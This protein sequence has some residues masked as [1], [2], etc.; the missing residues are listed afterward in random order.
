MYLLYK[1]ICIDD[2]MGQ[3]HDR[4]SRLASPCRVCSVVRMLYLSPSSETPGCSVML[5]DV[6]HAGDFY[7]FFRVFIAVVGDAR[8]KCHV[9]KG[10]LSLLH[11]GY[12]VVAGPQQTCR[13]HHVSH[14]RPTSHLYSIETAP[15]SSSRSRACI[16]AMF[17]LEF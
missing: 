14:R 17:S 5:T 10:S 1:S 13:T 4:S 8:M 3:R 16:Q 6:E 11:A 9:K 2:R 15:M 12:L 7:V